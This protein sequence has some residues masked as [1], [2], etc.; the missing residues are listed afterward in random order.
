MK[1]GLK[2]NLGNGLIGENDLTKIEHENVILLSRLCRTNMI[3]PHADRKCVII[4]KNAPYN[5]PLINLIRDMNVHY[6]WLIIDK[7]GI[8]NFINFNTNNRKEAWDFNRGDFHG[9]K[10]ERI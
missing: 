6:G 10:R 4:Q 3:F 2:F 9:V 7:N 5:S 1:N 8:L